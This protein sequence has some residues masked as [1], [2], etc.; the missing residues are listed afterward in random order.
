MRVLLNKKA[1][2][3]TP[4]S[5]ITNDQAARVVVK[6]LREHPERLHEKESLLAM[7][8]FAEAFPCK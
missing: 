6:Y 1:L 3:C 5:G 8:A 7:A 2:F 4:E